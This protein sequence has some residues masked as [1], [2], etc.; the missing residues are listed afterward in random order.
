MSS[1]IER[2]DIRRNQLYRLITS[3]A[4]CTFIAL[5]AEYEPQLAIVD[6]RGRV[7]PYY[8]K[9]IC[10]SHVNC[11]VGADFERMVNNARERRGERRNFRRRGEPWGE[12]FRHDNDAAV[13]VDTRDRR[14]RYIQVMV[15][16]RTRDYRRKGNLH[17][18]EHDDIAPWIDDTPPVDTVLCRRYKWQNIRAIQMRTLN[19]EHSKLYN[20]I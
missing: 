2:V 6:N 13:I 17:R 18:I 9:V 12:Y 19:D 20:I 3:R 10:R 7:C 5:D 11:A 8:G 15:M 1:R 16:S 14:R 4:G